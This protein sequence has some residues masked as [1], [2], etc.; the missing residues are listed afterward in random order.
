MANRRATVVRSLKLDGKWRYC[1]PVV[2][3][4]GRKE[5][6]RVS[7]D[8]VLLD[9][10]KF[11]VPMGTPSRWY[12]SW[13]EGSRKQWQRYES[14]AAALSFQAEQQAR[15]HAVA[16][17][18]TV[19]ADEPR[20][21]LETA[22]KDFLEKVRLRRLSRDAND[23]YSITVTAFVQGCGHRSQV[24]NVMFAYLNQ[25]AGSQAGL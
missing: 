17:G 11:L 16:A 13:Y 19:S 7:P 12:V 3:I 15:L 23:L 24:L 10:E 8:Y 1:S 4:K 14:M 20:T 6:P 5:K 9:G 2:S 22:A 21:N 18:V 25:Y